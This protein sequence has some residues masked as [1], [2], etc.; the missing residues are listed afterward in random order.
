M[1]WTGILIPEEYGG[2]DL[3]F[4]TFGIVLEELGR[5]LTASPLFASA[6]VGATALNIAGNDHQKQLYLPKIV[7]GSEILTLAVDESNRHAPTEIALSAQAS[8]SGYRLNGKKDSFWRVWPLLRLL[9]RQEP[10]GHRA[11]LMA[12]PYFWSQQTVE[13]LAREM[14][15]TADSRG[16][17]NLTF[18]DVEVPVEAVLGSDGWMGSA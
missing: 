14:L 1:G 3:D 18:S 5:Q 2:S 8:Q 15:S 17:A 9:W 7:D 16:Y 11:T 4:L 6:L 10:M 12:S 13:S